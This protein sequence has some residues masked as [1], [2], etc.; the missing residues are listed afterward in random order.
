VVTVE[1]LKDIRI[2]AGLSGDLLAMVAERVEVCTFRHDC[3]ILSHDRE[4][5]ALFL[6]LEGRVR[7]EVPCEG[8]VDLI[9]ELGKGDHVGERA[10]LTHDRRSA[11]VRAVTDVRVGRIS[12]GDFE[13][14][15]ERIPRIAVNL[16]RDLAQRLGGWTLRH[17][18]EESEHRRVIAGMTESRLF[19]ELS[20][21]PGV[22]PAIRELNDRIRQI[23]GDRH[24]LIV[25]E[26]GTWKDLAA[27]LIHDRGGAERGVIF[28]DCSVPTPGGGAEKGGDGGTGWQER[29]LFGEGDDQGILSHAVGGDLILR[30]V[31]HL[32]PELQERL[33]SWIGEQ[34][35]GI[36][37]IGTSTVPPDQGPFHPALAR[38]FGGELLTV[39]PLRERRQD[40]PVMVRALLPSLN[41][42]YGRRV[43]RVSPEGMNRLLE[44]DWPLNGSELQQ[45]LGRAVVMTEGETI[46]PEAILLQGGPFVDGRFDLLSIG[47][48]RQLAKHPTLAR[49]GRVVTV[50][51]FLLVLLG[52]LLGPDLKNPA[53]IAVWTL[54][55]PVL[56]LSTIVAAR[57]WCS[58]CP[59]ESIGGAIGVTNRVT[60][61][62]PAWLQR[63]GPPLSLVGIVLILLTEQATS[64]FERAR[65]TGLFL[66]I[67][68]LAT[69]ASDLLFGKRGWCRYLCPLGRI[70]GLFSRLS[71]VTLRST[72]TVCS[73]RCR[74]DSCVRE[75]GCPMGLHPN[76]LTPQDHCI[77]CLDCFRG[78][79]HR[80]IRVELGNPLA[81]LG[82]D[83]GGAYRD[84]VPL[85]IIGGVI[86]VCAV[87]LAT[88]GTGGFWS[89]AA[90]AG[91][92][93]AT[94][95]YLL[96]AVAAARPWMKGWWERLRG[97]GAAMVPL[98]FVALLSI[99]LRAIV[100]HGEEILPRMAELLEVG[101]MI[102]PST[103]RPELGTF[104]LLIPPLIL[105]GGW[106]SFGIERR[107]GGTG[108]LSVL[109]PLLLLVLFHLKV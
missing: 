29:V 48:F 87:P 23:P 53:N 28:L 16:C 8:G 15:L 36:R 17:S 10:I 79:P 39:P 12:H 86:A 72:E 3:V 100:D 45:V 101:S 62:P 71:L 104:A 32:A 27:R 51:L 25:G 57:G 38:L 40:I 75:R 69:V 92:V 82:E 83:A 73:S 108:L 97:I 18:R 13:D 52:T 42:K 35:R 109:T 93:V 68:L 5:E 105:L 7:V 43:K 88:G 76:G 9:A 14:L 33:C 84:L 78:C 55:W 61:T 60:R 50:L 85:L 1:D 81:T 99:Y 89:P 20:E 21:F 56:L 70:V 41:R 77:L 34:G 67:L 22:S 80:S 106:L 102:D 107:R 19:P 31:D 94:C 91:G 63:V 98:A 96:V 46:H 66:L 6:I 4:P 2:L 49:R 44:H 37:L 103:L 59:L 64:M 95:S 11:D 65:S 30:A 26:A 54:W 90:F 74:V 24:L 58:I 47:W